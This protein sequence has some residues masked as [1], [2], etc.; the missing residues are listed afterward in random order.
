MRP[1]RIIIF[2]KAPVPGLA[3]TRLIPSLGEEGAALLAL[4]FLHH[5]IEESQAAAIGSV[6]LCTTPEP[7]HASWQAINLPAKVVFSSQGEGDLGQ[8]MARA[9][10][11]RLAQNEAVL[12]T[13]TDCVPLDRHRLRAAADALNTHDCCLIPALDG[14]YVLLGLNRY[15]PSLFDQIPWSTAEVSDITRA[16]IRALGWSLA[17]LPTLRDTDEPA[18]LVRLPAD[19]LPADWRDGLTA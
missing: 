18:D 12:L 2:A 7:H 14:G 3:K 19:W 1:I 13:G 17:E 10:R 6:E 15:H 16:R 8:R 4:K 5:A 9:A 11:R